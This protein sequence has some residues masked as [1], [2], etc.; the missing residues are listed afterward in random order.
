MLVLVGLACFGLVF[1]GLGWLVVGLIWFGLVLVGLG[2][3]CLFFLLVAYVGCGWRVWFGLV[4]FG[5][6]WFVLVW[7]DLG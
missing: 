4:L 7:A 3:R 1:V 5:L 6:A 2:W